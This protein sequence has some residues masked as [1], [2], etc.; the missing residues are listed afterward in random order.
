MKRK[1]DFCLAVV[2]SSVSAKCRFLCKTLWVW[3]PIALWLTHS[4]H[5]SPPKPCLSQ[6]LNS[7]SSQRHSQ[8]PERKQRLSIIAVSLFFSTCGSDF[9]MRQSVF[10][11]GCG[12]QHGRASCSPLSCMPGS[13][14]SYFLQH[15]RW[16]LLTKDCTHCPTLTSYWEWER[17]KACWRRLWTALDLS[18][19]K[20]DDWFI[21]Q[22]F[23]DLLHGHRTPGPPAQTS[24]SCQPFHNNM[25]NN[26]EW[27]RRQ[28]NVEKVCLQAKV[29][30]DG[31]PPSAISGKLFVPCLLSFVV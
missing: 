22:S 3:T 19:L 26:R 18:W 23:R 1:I 5:T 30:V 12:Q 14:L 13:L 15:G 10:F 24:F 11:G 6:G 16:S 4:L 7:A 31:W 20:M 2:V 21:H 27:Q 29:W 9:A 17:G 28:G 8:S 25:H